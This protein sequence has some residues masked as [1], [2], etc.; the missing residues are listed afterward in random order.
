MSSF[1]LVTLDAPHAPRAGMAVNGE[2]ELATVL[3]RVLRHADRTEA[4]AGY[5][6]GLDLTCRDLVTVD[7]DPGTDLVCGKTQDTMAP[8][9]PVLVPARFPPDVSDLPIPLSVNDR[10]MTEMIIPVDEQLGMTSEH[11][12]PVPGDVVFT[13]SPAGEPGGRRLRPGDRITASISHTPSRWVSRA[14]NP[15]QRQP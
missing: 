6:I 9:G 10:P 1:A 11:I 8:C 14:S 4:V 7:N 15:E 3:G 5:T 13:G 2:R 12:T